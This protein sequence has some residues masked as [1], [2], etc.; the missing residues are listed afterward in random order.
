MKRN[1]I[2]WSA[3]ALAVIA[4]FS[5]TA[6]DG[7]TA[8]NEEL[9]AFTINLGGGQ[10]NSRAVYP[11][12]GV[13]GNTD[14]SAP[15]ISDLKFKAIFSSGTSVI[16]TFSS[17]G[18]NPLTGTIATG[19]YTISVE[20]Y[21]DQSGVDVFYAQGST[22]WNVVSG[23]NNIPIT[24]NSGLSINIATTNLE[25]SP[26]APAN[27]GTISVQL[28]GFVNNND[29][30]S[31][32]LDIAPVP[33]FS[34]SGHNASGIASAGTKTFNVTV[35]FD[36]TAPASSGL[37]DFLINGLNNPP[38]GYSTF[39]AGGK[40]YSYTV[41]D[42]QAAYNGTGVDRR[43]PV[44]GTNIGA[45]NAY[46]N[47]AN[48]LTRHYKLMADIPLTVGPNNWTAIGDFSA[49][50]PF[51]GSFD[52][53]GHY[54]SDLNINLP[55]SSHQGMFGYINNAVIKNLG[56]ENCDIEGANNVG[57][58]VGRMD[59]STIVEKCYVTGDITGTQNVGGIVGT[60]NAN[61]IQSCYF[62][63][64]VDGGDAVGG[65][66]GNCSSVNQIVQN[67]YSTGTVEGAMMAV[68]GVV[69]VSAK[70]I[71]NCYSTSSVTGTYVGTI[72]N[73]G[74]IIGYASDNIINCVALN[75][76]ITSEVN[77]ASYIG[78]VHGGNNGVSF[79]TSYAR[80]DMDIRYD[81]SGTNTSKTYNSPMPR[82]DGTLFTAADALTAAWW[83]SPSPGPGWDS[84]APWDFT[85]V[86]YPADGTYLPTL[87]GV[88]GT[89]NP[90]P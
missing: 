41:F 39:L 80:S 25:F 12:I 22:T 84:S 75:P 66:A 89:Q 8:S 43:I 67:C 72:N 58:F 85:N 59:G 17:L 71:K 26:I 9:A 2:F 78:R 23:Q 53:Q 11:P 50:A 81:V 76:T 82:V 49:T 44:T 13:N 16:A 62:Y 45:F 1:V 30:L 54:I 77:N 52:G 60:H 10:D 79:L 48:G 14:P 38:S 65:I 64:S 34:F 32:E 68:G 24:V 90:V 83:I 20:I 6:C 46:A 42:G 86:W 3:L 29:A 87:R 70:G 36:D 27:S 40:S 55:S 28:S 61:A 63:G 21:W 18:P 4:G 88:G 5:M 19:S 51:I 74:G 69:G 73:I 31:V 56:L 35:T 37:Y 15:N 57:G 33:G 47:T 7:N